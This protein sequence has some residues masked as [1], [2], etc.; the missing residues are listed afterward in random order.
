MTRRFTIA[1]IATSIL[2]AATLVSAQV[3]ADGEAGP[4]GPAT[5]VEQPFVQVRLLLE[6]GGLAPVAH[7]I[8]FSKSGS[9]FD[10]IDEGGQDNV[11][12]FWRPSA[13]LT[14][15][16]AHTL[17]L[18][19]QPLNLESRV[20]LERD[21]LV[22]EAVFPAGS[23]LDL[24]YGFDF[25]RLSY[26]YDFLGDRPRDEI[27]IGLSLQMRNATIDFTSTDGSVHRS[28]R[29]IGPV[30]AL[31]IRGRWAMTERA[32]IGGEADAIYAPIKYING[33]DSDVEGAFFDVSLRAAYRVLRSLDMFVNVRYIGGGAEGT[34]SDDD[35]PGDGYTSNWLHFITF[36]IGMAWTPTD[37]QAR[38]GG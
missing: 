7:S 3:Q 11:F 28:N 23:G 10:Y 33:S 12:L 16:G 15:G 25:Y 19:Y 4:T 27:A 22:D 9:R 6:L 8:Q 17:V 30:P 35:G 34:S 31:K 18:L 20:Y 32:W 1:A 13:E 29:D 21:I 2:L 14:L 37:L 38:Q 36:S 26:L 5:T 24:R